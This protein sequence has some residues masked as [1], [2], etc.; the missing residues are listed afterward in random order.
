MIGSLPFPVAEIGE[1]PKPSVVDLRN[2]Y[3]QESDAIRSLAAK[4]MLLDPINRNKFQL[5]HFFDRPVDFVELHRTSFPTNYDGIPHQD[6]F[7]TLC[8]A[9]ALSIQEQT[10][11]RNVSTCHRIADGPPPFGDFEQSYLEKSIPGALSFMLRRSVYDLLQIP[12]YDYT[13]GDDAYKRKKDEDPKAIGFRTLIGRT[14]SDLLDYFALLHKL[15]YPPVEMHLQFCNLFKDFGIYQIYYHFNRFSQDGGGYSSMINGFYAE[16]NAYIALSSWA[17]K[18][19]VSSPLQDLRGVDFIVVKDDQPYLVQ[20]K[21]RSKLQYETL[22][23][24]GEDI[25]EVISCRK[26][27][28]Y[29]VNGSKVRV[30]NDRQKMID[31]LAQ[32]KG[33]NKV[34][35]RDKG[36]VPAKPMW[37][38]APSGVGY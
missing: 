8:E 2:A 36:F 35:C 26:T 10:M 6:V 38:Y 34:R 24:S 9:A 32:I 18:I 16:M 28:L 11:K 5:G 14:R 30:E 19:R 12:P 23:L 31:F 3:F 37:V 20:V 25:C 29:T 4:P 17:Q 7:I 21:G 22:F 33:Y 27:D 13:Y 1:Q 15:E